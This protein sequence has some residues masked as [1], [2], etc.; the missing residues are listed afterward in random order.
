MGLCQNAPKLD[1]TFF[2]DD[3]VAAFDEAR[4]GSK[5]SRHKRRS[6]AIFLSTKRKSRVSH[7]KSIVTNMH[8]ET[9]KKCHGI[10]HDLAQCKTRGMDWNHWINEIINHLEEI[11]L[12]TIAQEA[13]DQARE[14]L[15]A[16]LTKGSQ[17]DKEIG[18]H[19]RRLTNM[20][21][22]DTWRGDIST[23]CHHKSVSLPLNTNL[24]LTPKLKEC[25]GSCE[26]TGVSD[27]RLTKEKNS[28]K[29]PFWEMVNLSGD[30]NKTC[31]DSRSLNF[32]QFQP[33]KYVEQ[34]PGL[35]NI[36]WWNFD[37]FGF[38]L[39]TSSKPLS[40]MFLYICVQMNFESTIPGINIQKLSS[41]ILEV[42]SNYGDNPYHNFIHGAD[43]LHSSFNFLQNSFLQEN[44]DSVHRFTLL[45]ASAIHDYNH[46]G[47][48]NDFLV[49]TGSKIATIY[50]DTSVLEN[51]HISQAFSLLK[52]PK[53]NFFEKVEAPMKAIIRT[54]TIQAV[55][56]T[57]MKRHGEHVKELQQ[58]I[59]KR[60]SPS[61]L[62]DPKKLISYA[63]HLS[64]LSHATKRFDIHMEWTR[65]LTNEFLAQ[66]DKELELGMEPGALFD[67]R[68]GNMEKG[69]IGFI[70][71]IILPLWIN[72]TTVIGAEDE[73][74]NQ[75][76][77][78]KG[79]WRR[80][81]GLESQEKESRSSTPSAVD[82]KEDDG[83]V[84]ML[85]LPRT[86]RD[87]VHDTN[88]EVGEPAME[89][90]CQT[91]NSAKR[92]DK[93][94]SNEHGNEKGTFSTINDQSF[95]SM[96]RLLKPYSG[97]PADLQ[98]R[99]EKKSSTLK[100]SPRG[101]NID[102]EEMPISPNMEAKLSSKLLCA[103]NSAYIVDGN[104]ECYIN[105]F[106]EFVIDPSFTNLKSNPGSSVSTST[107]SDAIN[108]FSQMALFSVATE[109]SKKLD[110][111]KI[112]KYEGEM[113]SV[114]TL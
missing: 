5:R 58:I 68:K 33:S 30:Q 12:K 96:S 82:L 19:F 74:I 102:E 28:D 106:R 88:C 60:K 87:N 11:K 53:Y 48:S 21:R 97:E 113:N 104:R 44:L 18:L 31:P 6:S 93:T 7:Q 56:M 29:T 103:S 57:D 52:K 71:F 22:G 35:K 59:E 2:E 69:Q 89:L 45:F 9:L 37:L 46:P 91:V 108:E 24:L 23:C 13:T 8:K 78:N 20:V 90:S 76:N 62:I 10:L 17:E 72:W 110:W 3:I 43:V 79:E 40:T 25:R 47:V 84:F 98:L 111:A 105:E 107:A 86:P 66:G 99:L 114:E 14:L 1:E 50:N 54:D 92:Q 77:V 26:Q 109:S 4:Q 70:D 81:A 67:R 94:S 38:S 63:L 100:F 16:A 34:F 49:N 51:W 39:E 36:L 64:D 101:K 83:P 61:D 42:E 112:D 75:I 15:F 85:H 32:G 80:R 55:L 65:R 41:F 73:W 95:S 27:N